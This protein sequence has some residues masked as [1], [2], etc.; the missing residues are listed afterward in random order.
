MACA[1]EALGL[2]L[3]HSSS[4]PALSP[5]KQAECGQVAKAMRTLLER[6]L[7][8]KDIVTKKSFENAIVLVNA[9]GGSTNAVL[10][11]LAM[12]ATADIDLKIDDFQEIGSRR[13]A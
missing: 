11:L 4:S 5:E 1:I 9:L 2:S 8:P 13:L 3:P 12:A 6:D 7:K 10:H